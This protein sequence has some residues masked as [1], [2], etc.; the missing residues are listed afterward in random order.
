MIFLIIYNYD[1]GIHVQ[2][3]HFDDYNILIQYLFFQKFIYK[4]IFY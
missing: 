2:Y 4:E 3:V 1:H